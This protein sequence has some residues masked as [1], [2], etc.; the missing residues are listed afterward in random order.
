[1]LACLRIAGL[2]TAPVA[3]L[4]T[5]WVGSPSAGRDSHPQD[6]SRS[7]M[8]LSLHPFLLDQH[9]LVALFALRPRPR[10]AMTP[11]REPGGPVL[12]LAA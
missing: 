3:R 4:T 10:Y 6:D 8:D 12:C 2:V 7:F 11:A 1:M 9:R 5:G